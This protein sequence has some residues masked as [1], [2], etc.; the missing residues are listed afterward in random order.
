MHLI[1]TN[2]HHSKKRPAGT[3]F[4]TPFNTHSGYLTL[5][6]ALALLVTAKI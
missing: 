3:E 4:F 6:A 5:Q 2:Y 1:Y